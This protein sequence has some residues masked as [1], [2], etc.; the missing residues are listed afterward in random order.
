VNLERCSD[1]LRPMRRKK[2]AKSGT[3]GIGGGTG[4]DCVIRLR[5]LIAHGINEM[6][7]LENMCDG[8]Q[9]RGLLEMFMMIARS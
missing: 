5:C 9:R 3:K 1:E 7:L 4:R 2:V 6:T 8:L